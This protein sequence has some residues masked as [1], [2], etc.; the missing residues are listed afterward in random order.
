MCKGERCEDW[1]SNLRRRL[2]RVLDAVKGV[3]EKR[4]QLQK[5]KE[6]KGRCPVQNLVPWALELF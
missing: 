2:L 3:G 6:K 1:G 4:G 5:V